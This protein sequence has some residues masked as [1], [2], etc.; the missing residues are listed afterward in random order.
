[1]KLTKCESGHFYDADKY[2]DCPYCNTELQ[3]R[4]G[5]VQ[6][7]SAGAAAVKSAQPRGPVAGWLV[8]KDGPARGRDL[9]LEEGRNFLGVDAA[10]CPAVLDADSPLAARQGIVVYD[11]AEAQWCALPGSSNELCALNGKSLLEKSPLTAGD[12]F[13]L[14]GASAEFV[15]YCGKERRWTSQPDPERT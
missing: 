3:H 10:G 1:M 9:R 12:V 5:I 13:T 8:V 14:G 2:P 4:A 11:P 7:G 15:P 6:P